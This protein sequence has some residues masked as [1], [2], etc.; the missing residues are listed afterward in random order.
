MKKT[1]VVGLMIFGLAAAHVAADQVATTGIAESAAAFSIVRDGRATETGPGAMARVQSGDVIETGAERLVVRYPND[2][3]VAL[4]SE[5]VAK[6][7]SGAVELKEGA[8]IA[9]FPASQPVAIRVDS[10]EIA[11]LPPEPA[12]GVAP[13]QAS[14]AGMALLAEM[15]TADIANFAVSNGMAVVREIGSG[16]RIATLAAG[17]VAQ[18]VRGVSGQWTINPDVP[19]NMQGINLG[20]E[21]IAEEVAARPII[22]GWWW[23]AAAAGAGGAGAVYY[24][25]DDDDDGGGGDDDRPPLSP[26]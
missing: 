5:S 23:G 8:A 1:L 26:R 2:S 15:P 11:A 17:E 6:L 14:D 25:T 4:K 3:I 19:F 18:L 21:M 12:T 22:A 24:I 9:G 7:D 10:I 20:P 13:T 16:K